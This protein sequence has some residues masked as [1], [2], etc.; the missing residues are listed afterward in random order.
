M[1]GKDSHSIE[2]KE[3]ISKNS[4]G[5]LNKKH[6]EKSKYKMSVNHAGGV[7][8]HSMKTKEKMKLN[9]I[10]KNKGRIPWNKGI[11]M[12]E[13]FCIKTKQGIDEKRSKNPNYINRWN[14]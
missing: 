4:K 9:S 13:E 8:K 6:T 2:S 3:K 14:N 10:G 5:F 1:L 11:K 7:E 12:N